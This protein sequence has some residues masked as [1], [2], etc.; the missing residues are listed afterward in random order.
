MGNLKEKAI[1]HDDAI[2][3]IGFSLK[4]STNEA[5]QRIFCALASPLKMNL[6]KREK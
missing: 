2:K 4:F 6:K 5:H 1:C 3:S